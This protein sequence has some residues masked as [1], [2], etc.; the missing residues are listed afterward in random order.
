[1]PKVSV[2]LANHNAG[3]FLMPAL[4]SIL[5]QTFADF[6]FIIFDDGSTDES[7]S[8]LRTL[9]SIDP[10]IRLTVQTNAGLTPTLNA[11]CKLARGTYLARMDADDIAMPDR[12]AQ[13]V[14]FLDSHPQCVLLGGAYEFIDHLDRRLHRM[15]P[16]AD[17]TTLQ[18]HCLSGRTPICHPLAMIRRSAFEQVGGYDESFP[19]AQDLDLFLRLGEVGT[20]AC[21]PEVLLQYR[22]HS[23]SVSQKKQ[24]LQ[25]DCMRRGCEAAWKRRGIAGEF[26]GEAGWRARDDA[27]AQLQQLLKYGWW[28]WNLGERR[29]AVAYGWA[30][31]KARPG[32]I[33]GWKLLICGGLKWPAMRSQD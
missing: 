1:M 11:A 18:Q 12:L 21:L 5:A 25:I 3:A 24:Q 17:D 10:R 14:R 30:A 26:L 16:P 29:T 7:V 4:K 23:T 27:D 9:E 19:V 13:Q 8:Q 28:A 6:E 22:L 15:I 32:S 20:M 2:I 33:D 31:I